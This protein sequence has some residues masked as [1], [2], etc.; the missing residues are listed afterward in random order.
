MRVK[1]DPSSGAFLADWPA[2]TDLEETEHGLQGGVEAKLTSANSSFAYEQ[3][4]TLDC[5]TYQTLTP[6][7]SN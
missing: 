1:L 3:P 2:T 5:D 7:E 4:D 6:I